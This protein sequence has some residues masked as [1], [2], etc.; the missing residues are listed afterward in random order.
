MTRTDRKYLAWIVM[1]VCAI[2]LIIWLAR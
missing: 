1:E 2:A